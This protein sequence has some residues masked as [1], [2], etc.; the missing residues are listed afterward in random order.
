MSEN[1]GKEM[2]KIRLELGITQKEFAKRLGITQSTLSD[3]EAGRRP[4]L[5]V[6]IVKRFVENI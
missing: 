6:Q 5:G 4:N 1:T 2:K 3:Y